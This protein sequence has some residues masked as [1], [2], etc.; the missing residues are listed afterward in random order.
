MGG[1]LLVC[2]MVSPI[3]AAPR[4]LVDAIIH[5]ESGGNPH[6]RGRH[7]EWGL[8]QIKCS[9]AR[10]VGFK[11][12]CNRLA[13]PSINRRFGTAYLDAALRRA[14]GNVDTAISLY[15]RGIYAKF[16]GCSAYCRKVKAAMK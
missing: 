10:S 16:R 9:T 3:E 11:G 8:M 13:D 1:L 15:Q 7:G 12:A 2:L 5:V 14:R 6:A 4:S